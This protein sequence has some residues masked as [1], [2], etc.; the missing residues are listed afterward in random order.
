MRR[1]ANLAV[2]LLVLMATSATASAQTWDPAATISAYSA[3]LSND[4]LEAALA[5]FDVNGSATDRAGHTFSGRDGLTTFLRENGFGQA[6]AR[7]TTQNLRVIANRAVWNY[8]CSCAD[9]STEVRVVV[10]S[11]HKISVF[12]MIPP[13]GARLPSR[14]SPLPFWLLASALLGAGVSGFAW[15]RRRDAH[16][17]PRPNQDGR[18]LAALREARLRAQPPC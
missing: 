4:D 7:L 13:P 8:T 12:A 9:G 1:A 14:P 3:A 16:N 6:D 17:W 10:N 2:A 18:L 11:E 5:L 15:R